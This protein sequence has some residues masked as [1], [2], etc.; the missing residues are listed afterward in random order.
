MSYVVRR[1][2]GWFAHSVNFCAEWREYVLP[3]RELATGALNRQE[4]ARVADALDRVC[5]VTLEFP[6]IT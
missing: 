1:R 4:I 6:C 5:D 2:R 3:I